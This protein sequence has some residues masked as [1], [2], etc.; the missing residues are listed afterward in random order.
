V[1]GERVLVVDDSDTARTV[2]TRTLERAGFTVTAASDGAEGALAALRERPAVVVTDLDMPVMD[3]HQLLRLLK[4]DPAT[5]ATPVVILTSHG[6]APSRFW[7][8]RIGADAYLTKDCDQ[9]ELVATVARLASNRPAGARAE[10]A[11]ELN[12]LEVLGRVVRQLDASLLQATLANTLLERG[13]GATDLHAASRE[14]LDVAARVA[15][16]NLLAIGVTESNAAT[17]HVL[18]A[19]PVSLRAAEQFVSAVLATLDPGPDVIPDVVLTGVTEGDGD[20]DASKIASFPLPLRGASGLLAVLPCEPHQFDATSRHLIQGL[21]THAGVVLDNARLGQRLQELSTLD[22][23]TRLLNHRAIHERLGHELERA[24]R[25]GRNLAVIICDLD[26]FKRVNDTHGHVAGDTALCAAAAAMT[27]M[28]RVSDACGRYGGEEFL[29]VLPET[30]LEAARQ[31]AER[32]RRAVAEHPASLSSGGSIPVTAS[33][34]VASH[35]ELAAGSTADT[36][37]SLADS[38]LYQA[39]AAGRNCVRP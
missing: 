1:S 10:A 9:G 25:H 37:V 24:G 8:S 28:L 5:A 16:A 29:V 2:L 38:R 30:D 39:K 33:F 6:E 26:F 13:I 22:G 32:L 20:A 15:D 23:L 35:A 27:R 3:G 17:L 31:V 4:S 21:T 12:P 36:L 18:V 19:Q 11:A 7:G 14:I 34:G